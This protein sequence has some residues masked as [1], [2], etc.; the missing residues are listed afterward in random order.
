MAQCK[1]PFGPR[2]DSI[3]N[4]EDETATMG[5]RDPRTGAIRARAD[6]TAMMEPKRKFH[7]L[8]AMFFCND[9]WEETQRVRSRPLIGIDP[10]EHASDFWRPS[11]MDHIRLTAL[12]YSRQ[13]RAKNPPTNYTDAALEYELSRMKRWTPGQ[14]EQVEFMRKAM[15]VSKGE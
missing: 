4:C 11:I 3:F 1:C 2:C 9:C 14:R 6:W 15:R 8:K 13:E 12:E 10:P 5:V 7:R